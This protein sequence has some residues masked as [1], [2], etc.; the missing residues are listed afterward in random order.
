MANELSS[1]RE[2]DYFE[3]VV[4]D[5]VAAYA[6]V[7]NERA[8]IVVD[9]LVAIIARRSRCLTSSAGGRQERD[10]RTASVTRSAAWIASSCSQTRIT[11]QPAALSRR[12]GVAIA[13]LVR[14]DLL[15]PPV[16]VLL[17]P[18]AVLGTAVPEAPVDEDRDASAS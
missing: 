5:A 18:G 6:D 12:V 10:C 3:Y 2:V 1:L 15:A 4:Q 9:R 17:R 16:G 14:F 7:A 11:V 13:A 8:A